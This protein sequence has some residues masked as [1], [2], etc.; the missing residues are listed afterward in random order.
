MTLDY[1]HHKIGV[2]EQHCE[3]VGRDPAEIKRTILMPVMVTDDN[4]AAADF[5]ARRRLGF[6]TVA[7]PRDYVIQRIS[8]FVDA[9]VDEIMFG[10]LPTGDVQQYQ[11]FNEE[12]L[13]VFQ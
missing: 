9:G 1:Y 13:S 2:L 4:A 5:I 8:E 6:G 7:G 11:R 10:G 3:K 12:I